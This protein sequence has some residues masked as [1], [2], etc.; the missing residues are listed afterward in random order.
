ML[1]PGAWGFK[2]EVVEVGF[3]GGGEGVLVGTAGVADDHQ[4]AGFDEAA[5]G[6]G[7]GAVAA[8]EGAAGEH[9]GEQ[10]AGGL[11]GGAGGAQ[12]QVRQ[13]AGQQGNLSH[14]DPPG[15]CRAAG[16]RRRGSRCRPAA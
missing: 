13:L 8:Q 15:S 10:L 16:G 11:S 6:G 2:F 9:A 4:P 1:S 5:E 3:S 12:E 7:V 14:G